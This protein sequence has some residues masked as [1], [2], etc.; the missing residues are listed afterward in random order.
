M[1]KNIRQTHYKH[2]RT[3][4]QT[5]DKKKIIYHNVIITM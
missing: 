3:K 1:G 4:K 5:A 2:K